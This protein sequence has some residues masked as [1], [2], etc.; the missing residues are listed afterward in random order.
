MFRWWTGSEWSD[1][2]A[3]ADGHTDVLNHVGQTVISLSV[4]GGGDAQVVAKLNEKL[5]ALP[6]ARIDQIQTYISP[7]APGTNLIALVAW[8]SPTSA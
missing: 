7:M 8:D 3:A 1:A 2:L 5:Q 4:L 6:P